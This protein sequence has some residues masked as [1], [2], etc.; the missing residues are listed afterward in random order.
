MFCLSVCSLWFLFSRDCLAVPGPAVVSQ[1]HT[2][3]IHTLR[4][5]C[6]LTGPLRLL[7]IGLKIGNIYA[8]HTFILRSKHKRRATYNGYNAYNLQR[9]HTQSIQASVISINKFRSENYEL[10]LKLA[11][12]SKLASIAA[13]FSPHTHLTFRPFF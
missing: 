1:Q 9:T 4:N 6:A 5:L 2:F 13:R 3:H 12:V 10:T 8:F 11:P 7:A